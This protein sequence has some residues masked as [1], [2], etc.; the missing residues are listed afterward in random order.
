MAA[1]VGEGAW[2]SIRNVRMERKIPKYALIFGILGDKKY[3]NTKCAY[4]GPRINP[5][6][7]TWWKY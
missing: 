3:I 1:L 5:I 2:K 4:E 6:E 7:G